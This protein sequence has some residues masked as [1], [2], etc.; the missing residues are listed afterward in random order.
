ME[1]S[2]HARNGSNDLL[3]LSVRAEWTLVRLDS[4]VSPD[5]A[6]PS[7]HT[8]THVEHRERGQREAK[9]S[10]V[11][12]SDPPV[13]LEQF[14]FP[15]VEYVVIQNHQAT[16][17][18]AANI[19]YITWTDDVTGDVGRTRLISHAFIVIPNPRPYD[20]I[21]GLGGIVLEAS[22]GETTGLVVITVGKEA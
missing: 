1:D 15:V 14:G 13:T 21:T 8:R 2:L 17:A 11:V 6:Q 16:V 3:R 19:A 10:Y 4:P 12:A 20:P 22:P 7:S 18:P 5:Y 9:Q